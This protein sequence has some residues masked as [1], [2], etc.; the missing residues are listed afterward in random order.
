MKQTVTILLL[1]VAA[2]VGFLAVPSV[3]KGDPAVP[4]F[5]DA[6]PAVAVLDLDAAM[7]KALPAIEPD[8]Y[9]M[10]SIPIASTRCSEPSE[11]VPRSAKRSHRAQVLMATYQAPGGRLELST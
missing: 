2:V 10:E 7:P 9:A 5:V 3:E 4:A 8:L 1:A 6:A 11:P